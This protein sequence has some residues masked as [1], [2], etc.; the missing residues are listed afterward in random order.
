MKRRISKVFSFI[1]VLLAIAVVAHTLLALH[2]AIFF[3]YRT[4]IKDHNVYSA[5]AIPSNIDT[6]IAK[7]DSIIANSSIFDPKLETRIIFARNHFYNRVFGRSELA[8]ATHYNAV[9]A[10]EID[11]KSNTLD[12][13]KS[14]VKMNLTSSL[15]HEMV[16]CLQ[17]QYHGLIQFNITSKPPFWKQEG[18]A[19]YI[20]QRAMREAIEYTLTKSINTLLAYRDNGAVK[21]WIN[22]EDGFDRPFLYFRS[23]LLVEYLL[24]VKGLPYLDFMD[25]RVEEEE[26]YRE[27]IQWHR[28]VM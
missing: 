24:D 5:A 3:Q 25:D 8:Y 11:V 27:M 9:L 1:V 16:H 14:R 7:V 2:P 26:A 15:A 19:E 6:I 10:G 23:R 22:L 12:W 20:S 17:S 21:G 13:E 28:T 18:Y 4:T